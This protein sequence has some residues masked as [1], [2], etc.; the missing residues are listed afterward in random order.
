MSGSQV[1]QGAARYDVHDDCVEILFTAAQIQEKVVELGR[2]VGHE[3]EH[4]RPIFMPILKGGFI[5]AAD[6]LRHLEPCPRGLEVEF[7]AASSYGKG[8]ET[9]G[10]VTV[11]FDTAS[12]KGR[13]VLLVDDLCDSG[14]TLFE[15]QRHVQEA[16][17]A[18][19]KSLVLL[20]KTAR[21]KMEFVPDFIGF[22]CPNKWIVGNGMDTAQIYRSLPYIG[23]LKSDVQAQFLTK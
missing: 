17:A 2:Q 4:L 15:V 10:T 1:E 14:L 21:R 23:V 12:V 9:S 6:L 8:T 19:V 3:Y 7:V 22:E 18:S 11:S 20:D 16:G 5:V 13:H